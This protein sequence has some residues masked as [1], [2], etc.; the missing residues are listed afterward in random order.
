MKST[1]FLQGT[2]P[3]DFRQIKV[4]SYP[5]HYGSVA[6]D[7]VEIDDLDFGEAG[8]AAVWSSGKGICLG[9]PSG[10]MVN[11]TKERLVY[12]QSFINGACLIKDYHVINTIY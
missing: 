3:N 10:R 6:T 2:A 1:W 9:L 7:Y 8:E 5:A 4:A 11:L 12:P